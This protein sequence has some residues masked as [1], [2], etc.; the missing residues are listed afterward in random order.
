MSDRGLG[1]VL[2][3]GGGGFLGT[4]LVAFARAR[5]LSVR[6]LSRRFYPH[7]Q[8]LGVEQIQGDVSDASTVDRAVRGCQTVFHT[9]AKGGLWGPEHEYERVER[10]GTRNVIAACRSQGR[11]ADRLH[12]LSQRGVQR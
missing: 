2:V 5:G 7:L 8:K 6:S 4:A 10:Q 9:A 11:A 12:Q 1:K 3:T